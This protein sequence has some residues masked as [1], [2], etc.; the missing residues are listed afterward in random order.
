[1]VLILTISAIAIISLLFL[2]N[3]ALSYYLS[4]CGLLYYLQTAYNDDISVEKIKELA[5]EA[6]KHCLGKFR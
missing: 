2:A 4:F 1:M 3:K 5:S 6:A